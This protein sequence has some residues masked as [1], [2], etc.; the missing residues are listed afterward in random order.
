MDTSDLEQNIEAGEHNF[1]RAT[2][3][4]GIGWLTLNE[5]ARLNPVSAQRIQEINRVCTAFAIDPDVRVV[6]VTGAGRGFCSGADLATIDPSAPLP[7]ASGSTIGPDSLWTLTYL[8]QPVIAMV[9]GPAIGYGCELALQADIRMASTDATFALPFAKLGTVS[10]TGAGTWLL[11][12]LVG[13]DRAAELLYTGRKVG[14]E[15]ALRLGLVTR[16]VNSSTL[17][18]ETR[19]LASA[20]ATNSPWSLRAMKRMLWNGL[21]HRRREHLTMQYAYQESGDPDFD[22]TAYLARFRG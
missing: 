21:E 1:V 18:E 3:E 13:A 4:D 11:P 6:V 19:Q 9:N 5:P 20:I 15:E 16:V 7:P 2:V 12:R 17:R 22:L 8:P 14:A 10:D